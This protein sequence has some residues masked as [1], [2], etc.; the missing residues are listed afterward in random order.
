MKIRTRMWLTLGA[1]MAVVLALDLTVRYQRISAEQFKEQRVDAYTIR[2]MLMSMRRVY[3]KQFIDS[4]LAITSKTVGFLPAHAIGRISK[5]YPNWE[6]SGI[7]FNNVSDRPRNPDNLADRFE[8]EAMD[9]FRANPKATERLQAIENEQ[10]VGW[11]HF[12][13]PI[14]IEPYCLQC[15]GSAA[16]APESIRETYAQAYDYKVGDLRGVL[17][18][19]LPL[20]R[21]KTVLWERWFDRLAWSLFSYALIFMALGFLM[22][23]LVLR[24]LA[25]VQAGTRQLAASNA[26]VRVPVDGNDELTELAR[27]FNQMADEV[28]AREQALNAHREALAQHRDQLEAQVQARTAELEQAKDAAEAANLAKSTFLANMSHEIRT[29]M[30]AI[31]GLNHLLRQAGATPEQALRLDKIDSAGRHLLAIINDI[32]DLSKIESGRLQLESTDFHLSAILDNVASIIGESARNKGLAIDVDGDAVPLWLRGDPTRLRQALLNYAGNAVKFTEQGRIALHAKLLEDKGDELRVRFEVTDTGVGIAPDKMKRL[33]QAF[34]QADSSTTRNHGGTGLGLAITRRLAHLMG[35]E[36]G[37]D[38]TP[39]VGSTFWFNVHLQRGHGIMP[40]VLPPEMV[41]AETQLRQHHVSARLL[42]VEDN[43]INCEVAVELLHGVGLAVETASDGRAA[44]EMARNNTYDL[45]L[46]DVQMPHMDGLEAT[47]AIRALPGWATKPIL[48]MTANAFDE[49]KRACEEA[50]MNDFVAK[51]VEPGLLYTKLLKW[52]P[53]SPRKNEPVRATKW[54]NEAPSASAAPAVPDIRK[55]SFPTENNLD[56]ARLAQVPGMNV[57]RGLAA[58]RGKA[59][60]Y[61]D[62]LG[63]FVDSHVDD[64]TLLGASLADGDHATALRLAHTL[65]GTGATLGADRLAGMAAHLEGLL[66]A[67]PEITFDERASRPAFLPSDEIQLGMEAISL[68]LNLLAAALPLHPTAPPA[69]HSQPLD[70]KALKAV[71]DQLDVL[72][73]QSDTAALSLFA[74]HATTLSSAFGPPGEELARQIKQFDFAA[75][76]QTLR[77]LRA[78]NR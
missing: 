57:T 70:T 72:L 51:P 75:A 54:G 68:E 55:E 66:R 40:C 27:D 42:L 25:Q 17:S 53:E 16:E 41:D 69:T 36:S 45:I 24:R 22:D 39:G 14:W 48:A 56:L 37:A 52:L 13:A 5:D 11:M 31:I 15:H 59:D 9:W 4:G 19:K 34:E 64:M 47:R 63:R 38:S 60:K 23:R 77:A 30:N 6:K 67:T 21:Y 3:H 2:S 58:L 49:D 46:M 28:S 62:L 61:L 44:L 71:L 1:L 8:L 26:H 73:A 50:G 18:I 43:V 29:P 76:H 7:S 10:G 12:T 78:Q 32:L 20:A 65:K 33:F 35:G 74:D